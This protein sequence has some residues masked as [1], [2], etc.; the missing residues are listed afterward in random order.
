ML[1]ANVLVKTLEPFN[2][3]VNAPVIT[4]PNGC[5]IVNTVADVTVNVQPETPIKLFPTGSVAL[6]TA[7]RTPLSVSITTV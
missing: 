1:P 2:P 6:D 4:L 7:L 3:L 5:P